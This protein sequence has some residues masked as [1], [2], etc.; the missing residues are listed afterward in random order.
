[1]KKLFE[2]PIFHY[3][4]VL[5]MV[6]IVCGLMIGGVNAI[7]APII[8]EN[9]RKA[10]AAAYSR[11]LEGLNDYEI[12][13]LLAEDPSTITGKVKGFDAEENVIGFIYTAYATNKFG[14]MRLVV[15]VGTNGVILGADFI[16]INQTYLVDGTRTNLS[17]YVGSEINE[18][19]PQGD[20]VSGATGSLDTVL[21][22][23]ND[24][25]VAH[26]NTYEAPI[27]EDGPYVE[28]FGA[29]YT[30]APDTTFT[31]TDIVKAKEIVKN[32]NNEV[33]GAFYHLEGTGVYNSDS[34]SSGTINLY[35]GVLNDGTI[36]GLSLPRDEYGHTSSAL[37]YPRV[38][39]YVQSLKGQSI[40]SFTG[41][42]TSGATNSIN[43]IDT[44]LEAL[45]GI[46]G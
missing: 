5:T 39:N 17:R 30:M 21:R 29:G 33:I 14:Y 37:F 40:D 45:G 27:T 42:V 4:F 36:A 6:A 24:I 23:L 2:K 10:Q 20:L 43:L 1:M 9:I 25:A 16:E 46:I 11:V 22:L 41:D 7:T 13:E 3:T 15:S 38:N 8:D 32:A 19:L 18:L 26:A 31:P 44:M 34:G 12:L 28:W 35:L